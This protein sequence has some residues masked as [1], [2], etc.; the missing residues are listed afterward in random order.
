MTEPIPAGIASTARRGLVWTAGGRVF[1]QVL[2]LVT[3]V[4]TARF[5][6]P[7]EFGV[8]GIVL[9]VVV[10]A[11]LFND[12]GLQA[13]LVHHGGDLSR[14]MLSTAFVV[15]VLMGLA[16]TA[17]IA[18]VAF[19][20]QAVFDMPDLAGALIVAGLSFSVSLGVVPTALLERDLRFRV[21]VVGEAG[22]A[23]AGSAVA[24][25]A[26]ALNG[27]GVARTWRAGPL[28]TVSCLT[29]YLT[30]VTRFVPRARPSRAD[31]SSLWT[32][33]GGMIKFT[34]TNFGTRNL[35]QHPPRT[36]RG[37][38]AAWPICAVLLG[39]DGAGVSG[40]RHRGPCAVPGP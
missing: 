21:L 22:A 10:L 20:V 16:L 13:A 30:A 25:F 38:P 28:V 40:R 8:Y 19:P 39:G 37:P 36:V 23:M 15:N 33:S 32:F 14:S 12:M 4:V 2:Q 17:F 7:A 27:S 6:S 35:R 31:F 18:A 9:V 24:I 5:L 3:F 29:A 34:L 26:V 1:A 11:S